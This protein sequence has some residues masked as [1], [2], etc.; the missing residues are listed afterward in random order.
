MEANSIP[1]L[2]HVTRLRTGMTVWNRKDKDGIVTFT[3]ECILGKYFL[4]S[5]KHPT[6]SFE[7][8]NGGPVQIWH[9]CGKVWA[10]YES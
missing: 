6:I 8:K 9:P 7:Q 5:L 1:R 2:T 10:S 4:T 3:R